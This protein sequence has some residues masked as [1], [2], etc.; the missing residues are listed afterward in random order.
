MFETRR[1][2]TSHSARVQGRH[3]VGELLAADVHRGAVGRLQEERH[4]PRAR[5]LGAQQLPANQTG[6]ALLLRFAF[7]V[8]IRFCTKDYRIQ[9]Q[10]ALG[11]L[12]QGQT[13]T[14]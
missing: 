14:K 8:L 9:R 6:S 13:L 4:R 3:R 12:H 7:I 1:R 10:R 2:A 11:V 5:R